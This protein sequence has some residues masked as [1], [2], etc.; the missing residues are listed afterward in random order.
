MEPINNK[1]PDGN[2]S[3]GIVFL[4]SDGLISRI[5]FVFVIVPISKLYVKKKYIY[6]VAHDGELLISM[7]GAH[8]AVL[9]LRLF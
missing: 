2:A 3:Y 5:F 9:P 6:Y 8:D 1:A 7:I 4:F